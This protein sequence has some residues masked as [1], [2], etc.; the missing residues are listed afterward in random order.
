MMNRTLVAL[1]F[2]LAFLLAAC[3]APSG[4]STAPPTVPPETSEPPLVDLTKYAGEYSVGVLNSCSEDEHE[5]Y[6]ATYAFADTGY[7]FKFSD[8]TPRSFMFSLSEHIANELSLD[9]STL[10]SEFSDINGALLGSIL[11]YGPDY[12]YF[13]SSSTHVWLE[14]HDGNDEVLTIYVDRESRLFYKDLVTSGNGDV[15]VEID[16]DLQEGWNFLKT[17]WRGES[18]DSNV[19]IENVPVANVTYKPNS[20]HGLSNPPPAGILEDNPL[21][22]DLSYAETAGYTHLQF[23]YYKNWWNWGLDQEIDLNRLGHII[24]LDNFVP[25]CD[26]VPIINEYDPLRFIDRLGI[27]TDGTLHH[28][29]EGVKGTFGG[30]SVINQTSGAFEGLV[31]ITGESNLEYGS[32]LYTTGSGD[33]RY[34]ETLTGDHYVYGV[35]ATISYDVDVTLQAGWN[36]LAITQDVIYTGP[37]GNPSAI[38]EIFHVRTVAFSDFEWLLGHIVFPNP[39]P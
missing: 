37:E 11:L 29:L 22:L 36:A 34:K 2:S 14:P 25:D 6:S 23:N 32:L 27:P 39:G 38:D 1:L 17:Q 16:L 13:D 8:H 3:S 12:S 35:T 24:N 28:T 5:G 4:D 10:P 21:K 7:V 33:L 19:R 30:L 20:K 31:A 15:N 9:P 26:L 18:G